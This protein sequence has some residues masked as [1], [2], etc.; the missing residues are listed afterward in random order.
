[1][2]RRPGGKLGDSMAFWSRR[3]EVNFQFIAAASSGAAVLQEMC[4][5]HKLMIPTK[6]MNYKLAKLASYKSLS[7]GCILQNAG[8]WIGR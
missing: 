3:R 4:Q 8:V 2:V 1:M 6:I 7:K 5:F